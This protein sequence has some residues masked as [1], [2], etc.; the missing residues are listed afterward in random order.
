M[1][2]KQKRLLIRRKAA[3][4]NRRIEKEQARERLEEDNRKAFEEAAKLKR[5]EEMK[6]LVAEVEKKESTPKP[7][8]KST[9]KTKAIK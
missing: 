7:K 1:K 2:P 6:A 9:R 8:R 5:E 3:E 4:E